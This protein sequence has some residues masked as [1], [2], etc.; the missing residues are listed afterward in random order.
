MSHTIITEAESHYQWRKF[1]IGLGSGSQLGHGNGTLPQLLLQFQAICSSSTKKLTHLHFFLH[2]TMSGK[3]PSAVVIAR[4]NVT[5]T[6]VPF[7]EVI[8]VDDPLT[9]GPNIMSGVI[10]NA[11]GLWVSTGKDVLTLM[12]YLDFGFTEG[13][14]NGSS[15]SMFSRNPI[16]ETDRELAVVGERGKFRMAK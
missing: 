7:G 16:T 4:P 9:I 15:I 10:G 1:C 2:D 6:S 11:Q 13:E 5:T 12:V 8:V 3:D 14:F